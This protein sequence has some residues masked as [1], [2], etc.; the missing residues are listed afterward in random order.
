M[1]A[2]LAR[3][4]ATCSFDE[5]LDFLFTFLF[6]VDERKKPF[7]SIQEGGG[8][9]QLRALSTFLIETRDFLLFLAC[10]VCATL[11]QDVY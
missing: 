4:M 1:F 9:E 6:A 11:I 3:L 10:L 5:I 7:S 2:L 8:G